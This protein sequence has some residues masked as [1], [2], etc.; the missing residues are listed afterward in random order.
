MAT[1]ISQ[2]FARVAID[3]D[4]SSLKKV[5]DYFKALEAKMKRYQGKIGG[6]LK[7]KVAVDIDSRSTL[8]NMRRKLDMLG[9]NLTLKVKRLQFDINGKQIRSQAERQLSAGIRVRVTP[10]ITRNTILD[11][12]RSI[13]AGLQNLPVTVRY[14][15]NLR[16]SLLSRISQAIAPSARPSRGST[17]GSG[18]GRGGSSGF[19][20]PSLSQGVLG[21]TLRFGAGGLPLVGGVIGFNQLNQ[22]NTDYQ[23]QKLAAEGIF[24]GKVPGGGSAARQQLYQLAQLNGFDYKETLPNFTRF[25]ASTMPSMGYEGGFGAFRSI[26]EFGRAR[27]ATGES[28]ERALYAFSQIASKGKVM[29]EELF[30]QLSEAAGFGE[31]GDIF[32]Q[33]YAEK[34]KSG[35]T[36]Q[37]AQA[38][39][40]DAMKAG[41]VQSADIFPIVARI[42][43]ERAAPTLEKSRKTADAQQ[44]RFRNA[45]Q[46]FMERFSEA[47]GEAGLAKFWDAAGKGM[48]KLAD[49][50]PQLA[51]AFE[52]LVDNAVRL[53]QALSDI[54]ETLWGGVGN[55]TTQMIKDETGVNI[56]AI[57]DGVMAVV[58][59]L[60]KIG[61]ALGVGGSLAAIAGTY[62]LYKLGGK[63]LG[64]KA[65]DVISEKTG[66]L[67]GTSNN[68]A[69][70]AMP[71]TGALRVWVVNGAGAGF[72]TSL[73]DPK[74]PKTNVPNSG[75]KW[76]Q[77]FGWLSGLGTAAAIG[78]VVGGLA[79]INPNQ[80]SP[81]VTATGDLFG[82]AAFNEYVN[83]GGAD[84]FTKKNITQATPVVEQAKV[85]ATMNHNIV[86]TADVKI[87]AGTPEAA[88]AQFQQQ[89]DSK[90][91][92]PFMLQSLKEAQSTTSIYAR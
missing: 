73:P 28:M 64:T 18:G 16:A 90:V 66:G 9:Q 43:S 62:G 72:D 45:R 40:R 1:P 36:G 76:W 78:T 24:A 14:A 59:V 7:I 5:D 3:V 41:K 46:Q 47:G 71:G 32:A 34:T 37:K 84:S 92:Q 10:W 49:R 25:M 91:F 17:G 60:A 57:R 86:L 4:Q 67:L 87:E 6:G 55:S 13:Q 44:M 27:G 79:A 80:N 56:V 68:L 58:S 50:A 65:G 85:Q 75:K 63:W 19:S 12:R 42:M 22:A 81:T 48:E 26:T 70:Y 15:G 35:L 31:A 11:L 8:L 23:S 54:S 53:A 89:L 30:G 2:Y 51:Q 69:S 29:S 83:N 33:A 82:S 88:I 38:A 39:L 77:R 74:T 61:E 21:R 52:K 20:V